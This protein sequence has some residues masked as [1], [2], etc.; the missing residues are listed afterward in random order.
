MTSSYTRGK[1]HL[2]TQMK[3]QGI[4]FLNQQEMEILHSKTLQLLNESGCFVQDKVALEILEKAGCRVEKKHVWV[5]PTLVEWAIRVA[6]SRI[7][8][9]DRDGNF[10]LDMGGRNAYYGV[11]SAEP[12]IIDPFT[13]EERLCTEQ[14]NFNCVKVADQMPYIDYMMSLCQVYDHP[15][16]SYQHEYAAMIRFSDKPQVVIVDDLQ[17]IKDVVE[18]ASIVR[19]SL[20]ELRRKPL[21]VLYCEPTSPLNCTKDSIEKV[22]YMAENGLPVLYAPIPMNGATGPMTMAAN[23]IQANAE[24]LIGLLIAELVNPGTPVMFGGILTNMDMKSLQ[25]T[26]ASPETQI[27]SIAGSQIARDLYHLPTW[28]TAGCTSSKLPDEQ[29][30]LEGTQYITTSGM[31]GINCIHDIGYSQF[32]LTLSMDLVVMMNDA[33]GRV[34]RLFDCVNVSDEY[35]LM[36]DMR[37]VGPKGHF[38][39]QP[40]TIKYNLEMWSSDIEDR[41]EVSKWKE[42]GAKTMGQRANE[43]VRDIIENGEWNTLPPEIDA[44][45]VAVIDRID[46]AE[47]DYLAAKAAK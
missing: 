36:D 7:H 43:K 22:R 21:F 39:G 29:A 6:P 25:P 32:G 14:D 16:T 18:M 3:N 19:G 15:K 13:G 8:L 33:V 37:E 12:R 34:R 4:D 44:Q 1:K 24:G 35:C 26:Y 42:L 40:S 2:A 23:I 31:G 9:Y 17:G 10:A 46:K 11:G 30:V 28:G 20:E 47:A 5:P 45:I 41:W 27:E 38:L